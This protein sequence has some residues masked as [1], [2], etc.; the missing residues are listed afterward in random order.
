MAG[1]KPEWIS[2]PTNNGTYYFE[3]QEDGTLKP[4][5]S[6]MVNLALLVSIILFIMSIFLFITQ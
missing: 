3:V 4:N 6:G 5:N 1:D 2:G